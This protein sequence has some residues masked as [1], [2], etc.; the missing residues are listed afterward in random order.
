M[1]RIAVFDS[2]LG[3]LSVIT[4]IRRHLKCSISYIADLRSFPYGTKS[5]AELECIIFDMIRAIE[6][7]LSPDYIVVG[8]NTPSIMLDIESDR[9]IGIRPPLRLAE[10]ISTSKDIAILGT[11]TTVASRALGRYIKQSRLDGSTRVTRINCSELVAL[12]ESGDFLRHPR[13]TRK[14]IRSTLGSRLAGA[15]VATLSSTHLPF[16]RR[17]LEE[18]YPEVTF[19]DPAE[20]LARRLAAASTTMRRG[21]LRIYA[22]G[23]A[24]TF[25]KNLR[26]MG[27]HHR[28]MSWAD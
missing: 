17:Y 28:V 21:S 1:T 12:V 25:V 3:S 27:M 18:I 20:Q 19:L 16:L 9:I 26:C 23:R 14:T 2:G 4:A 24:G 22:T 11:A 5:A 8:S 10:S 7:R 6:D 15:D 13:K